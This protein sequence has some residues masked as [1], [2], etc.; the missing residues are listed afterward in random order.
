MAELRDAAGL[1]SDGAMDSTE[2]DRFIEKEVVE[3]FMRKGYKGGRR[4]DD[5][6]GR[7]TGK[8]KKARGGHERWTAKTGWVKVA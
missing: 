5:L 3:D 4:T 7:G 8:G 6:K 2:S 1:T